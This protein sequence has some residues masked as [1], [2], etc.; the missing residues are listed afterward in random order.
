MNKEQY[1]QKIQNLLKEENWVMSDEE[2]DR[3]ILEGIRDNSESLEGM[4]EAIKCYQ[5]D[6][7]IDEDGQSLTKF[8]GLYLQRPSTEG[9]MDLTEVVDGDIKAAAKDGCFVELKNL[10]K[11]YE[12]KFS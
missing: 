2:L 4:I 9:V 3:Q 12:E 5:A 7:L 1:I 6:G 10:I 8:N 11:E